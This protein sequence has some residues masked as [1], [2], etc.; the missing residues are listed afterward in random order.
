MIINIYNIYIDV[1]MYLF[2]IFVFAFELT[3][4]KIPTD[5]FSSSFIREGGLQKSKYFT[6]LGYN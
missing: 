2:Q 1:W 3:F 6:S 4:G 5:I